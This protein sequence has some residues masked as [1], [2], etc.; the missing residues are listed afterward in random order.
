AA[1]RGFLDE[2]RR[3]LAEGVADLPAD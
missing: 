2:L 1:A 3:Q